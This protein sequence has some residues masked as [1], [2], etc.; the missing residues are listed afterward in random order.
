[1][2]RRG[3]PVLIWPK[4]AMTSWSGFWA[5]PMSTIVTSPSGWLT[6]RGT[7][8][9]RAKIE[10]LVLNQDVSRTAR[11]HGLWALVGTGALE[12]DFHLSLLAHSDPTFRA[13]GVRAAGNMG[14]VDRAVRDR[15]VALARDSSPDVRLQVVIGAK[16]IDGVDPLP[17]LLDVLRSVPGDPLIPQ[18]VWQNL[19][20]LVEDRQEELDAGWSHFGARKLGSVP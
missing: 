7:E 10:A 15:V 13:W 20:P 11:M 4:R 5:V 1:M 12:L 18:I 8:S 16:K 19:Q 3:G 14:K 6:E 9:V 17:V 2:T